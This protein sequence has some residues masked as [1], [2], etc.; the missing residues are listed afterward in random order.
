MTHLFTSRKLYILHFEALYLQNPFLKISIFFQACHR[1]TAQVK[2]QVEKSHQFCF[3][4]MHYR[5]H[6]KH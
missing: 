2:D 4:I 1:F 3:L 5:A 6:H